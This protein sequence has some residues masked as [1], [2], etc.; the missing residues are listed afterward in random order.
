MVALGFG[1]R[2]HMPTDKFSS[3]TMLRHRISPKTMDFRYRFKWMEAG[4]EYEGI[5]MGVVGGYVM[6][7][8]KWWKDVSSF[9]MRLVSRVR[10]IWKNGR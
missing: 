2:S 10:S 6:V 4:E 9:F 7:E 1:V 5:C 8:R 3:K